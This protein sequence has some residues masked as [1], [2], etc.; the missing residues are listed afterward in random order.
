[1]GLTSRQE[2]FARAVATGKPAAVAYREAYPK[3]RKWKDASVCTRASLVLANAN[4][5]Q[6]VTEIRQAITD[7]AVVEQVEVVRELAHM[8]RADPA[9]AYDEEGRLKSI[10][11]I[12]RDLR[13]CIAVVKTR[14]VETKS[15]SGEDAPLIEEYVTELKFWDKQ[16]TIDK[17]MKHLG[18]Y[19]KDNEQKPVT[20]MPTV[21][22]NIG[23]H[24]GVTIDG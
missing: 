1:M 23:G 6:R 18:G 16:G 2:A 10:H 4:V 21:N 11:D 19:A 24:G 3:S 15:R 13:R 5:S 22:I 8:L 17:L 9:D 14:R 7:A 12:P 20:V